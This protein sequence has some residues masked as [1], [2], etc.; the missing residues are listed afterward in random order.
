MASYVMKDRHTCT[1]DSLGQ[2]NMHV[3]Q[4]AE[5]KSASSRTSL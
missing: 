3:L 5:H 1:A 4:F 2:P